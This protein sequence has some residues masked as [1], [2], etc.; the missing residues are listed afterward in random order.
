MAADEMMKL[1]DKIPVRSVIL[2]L[3]GNANLIIRDYASKTDAKRDAFPVKTWKGSVADSGNPFKG[4]SSTE[5][6]AEVIDF[7][8]DVNRNA[9]VFRISTAEE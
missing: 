1:Y 7:R 5:D 2:V 9:Y 8:F 4:L 6:R 3:P